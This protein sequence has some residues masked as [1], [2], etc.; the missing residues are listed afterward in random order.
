MVDY[1]VCYGD[2]IVDLLCALFGELSLVLR[3]SGGDLTVGGGER[4][5]QPERHPYTF[6]C[7]PY[8]TG[9]RNCRSADL[10]PTCY[11]WDI[12]CS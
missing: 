4:F 5:S 10:L 12:V 1:Y 2:D 9:C 11:I 3:R 7:T 6:S 8:Y